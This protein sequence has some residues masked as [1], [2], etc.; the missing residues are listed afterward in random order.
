MNSRTLSVQSTF[1]S[2]YVNTDSARVFG[3][4]ESLPVSLYTL[5]VHRLL[6]TTLLTVELVI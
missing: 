4:R 5:L 1:I 6:V 3:T 2:D